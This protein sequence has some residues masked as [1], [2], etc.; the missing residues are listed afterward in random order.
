LG[1]DG[2]NKTGRRVSDDRVDE[3][4]SRPPHRNLDESFPAIVKAAE[5]RL[6]HGRLGSIVDARAG[7]G[8]E[9]DDKVGAKHIADGKQDRET[10]LSIA[11]LDLR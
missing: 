8:V 1:F 7:R 2:K 11:R 9:M 4:A 3:P 6:D 5:Q 10:G